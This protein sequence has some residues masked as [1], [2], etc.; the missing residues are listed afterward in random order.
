MICRTLRREYRLHAPSAAAREA[1]SFMETRP[2]IEGPTF[3]VVDIAIAA[4]HG[5]LTATLPN[6]KVAAGTSSHFL[7]ALHELVFWDHLASHGDWPILHGA[8]LLVGGKRLVVVG[9]KGQGK[10]T[11]SAHLL[12]RGHAVEGDEHVAVGETTVVARPRSLRIKE[13][14]FALLPELPAEVRQTPS[15][16]TWDGVRVH[17]VDPAVFGRPWRIAEGPAEALIFLEPNHGGRSVAKPIG[18]D[19]A[20]GRLM[21]NAHFGNRNVLQLA[22]RLRGL[23]A[24]TPAY[25]LRLGDLETAEWHLKA[26][27]AG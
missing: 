3:D 5:F 6:G 8:A 4:S 7:S 25:G 14:S 26:I 23:A 11:L 20:F 18:A 9:D 21:E 17:A 13:S 19:A 12:L 2:E 16:E 15:V 10:S 27:A 1:L 22:A 24:R